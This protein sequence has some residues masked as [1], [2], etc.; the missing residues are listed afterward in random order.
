MYWTPAQMVAHHSSNGCSLAAGD[1]IGSGTCSGPDIDM[2]GCLLERSYG[3]PW[4]LSDGTPRAWLQDCDTVTLTGR[5]VVPG[6]VPIGFGE[7]RGTV[8]PAL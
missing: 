2:A 7:A 4:F 6:R 8:L 1:L 5:A 3:E